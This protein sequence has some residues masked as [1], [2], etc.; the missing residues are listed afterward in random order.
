MVRWFR[1]QQKAVMGT[2]EVDS[3]GLPDHFPVLASYDD[4]MSRAM[5]PIIAPYWQ[6]SGEK[7]LDR[8]EAATGLD[9]GDW[10]V[11]NPHLRSM[12]EQATLKFC[13]STNETTSRDLRTALDDL[14]QSLI[15]GLVEKGEAP[16]ELAKRVKE[17]FDGCKTWKAHQIAVT[18]ASRAVH[19]AQEQAAIESGVVAGFEWILSD[20]AC[21]MCQ[22]QYTQCRRVR[23]GQP[24]A[25]TGG[26]PDYST[27]RFPPLHPN[28]QCSVI[29]ILLPEYG[30]PADPE[31][32][33][34]LSF[35]EAEEKEAT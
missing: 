6:E 26:D 20:D 35:P 4:P 11:V 2:I 8:L 14:R 25:H 30:G 27:V 34:T 5:T 17:I 23:L 33:E 3:A 22:A 29:E 21:P 19:A 7:T 15:E 28:D 13:R 31:W 24:F 12:I 9:L 16:R 18:E 32:G 10:T 1:E